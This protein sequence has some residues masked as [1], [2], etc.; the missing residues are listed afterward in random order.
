M[1]KTPNVLGTIASKDIMTAIR[2]AWQS[3]S[4]AITISMSMAA[5]FSRLNITDKFCPETAGATWLL[6]RRMAMKIPMWFAIGRMSNITPRASPKTIEGNLGKMTVT[7]SADISQVGPA[8]TIASMASV[9]KKLHLPTRRWVSIFYG[10]IMRH[11]WSQVKQL[12]VDALAVRRGNSAAFLDL[13]SALFSYR[14]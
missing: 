7:K 12:L 1:Y 6:W 14:T 2:G 9:D 3:S 8:I 11:T 5:F 4:R 13:K 10:K